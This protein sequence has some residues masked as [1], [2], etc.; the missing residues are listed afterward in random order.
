VSVLAER[1]VFAGRVYVATTD[2]AT[3]GRV[4]FDQLPS[5]GGHDTIRGFRALRFRGPHALLLQGEY[6][7]EIWS[8]FD[9]ALFYDAGKVAERRADL[10]LEDLERAYG[11][12]FRFNTS[13][14]VIMRV[15]AGFGSRDG[16][17]VYVV[18][19]GIF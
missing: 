8:A 3:G 12:G 6:R 2:V 15:D 16:R 14:G 18:F 11:I 9:A 7:W 5:L 17:H 13:D 19:G 4:P 10:T 1:R